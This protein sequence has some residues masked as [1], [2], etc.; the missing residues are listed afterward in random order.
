M[1]SDE[2]DKRKDYLTPDEFRAECERF[3]IAENLREGL[4]DWFQDLGVAYTYKDPFKTGTSSIP[5]G[6]PMALTA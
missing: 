3:K 6:S 5:R 2:K 1:Q 4:L